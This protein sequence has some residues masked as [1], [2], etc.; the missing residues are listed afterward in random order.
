VIGNIK[1]TSSGYDPDGPRVSDPTLG[2]DAFPSLTVHH[3]ESDGSCH[4][5]EL[6][7]DRPAPFYGHVASWLTREN[8]AE[9]V[10]RCNAYPEMVKLAGMVDAVDCREEK[11]LD[12]SE[13]A[14]LREATAAARGI[15]K[16]L[17]EAKS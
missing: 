14:M 1:V 7:D 15:L 10:R 9:I 4:L 12:N 17:S 13:W 3:R 2:V 5:Y 11:Y 6:G 16:N 8:A